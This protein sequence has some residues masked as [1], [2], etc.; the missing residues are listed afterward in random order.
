MSSA[1][2]DVVAPASRA[3][4]PAPRPVSLAAPLVWFFVSGACALV[5]QVVW[6]RRMVLLTGT[7]TAAVSTVLGVFMAGLGLGAWIFGVQADRSSR[8]LK[9][10]AYLEAGIALY[11]LA[12]PWLLGLCTPLYVEA[13]RELAGRPAPLLLL[14]VTLG[15][16]LLIVPTALM[17]GTFPALVRHVASDP[18]RFGT[19]LGVL[20]STNLAGGVAGSLAAGFVL[21]RALGVD[22]ATMAAVLANLA[23]AASALLW[24]ERRASPPAAARAVKPPAIGRTFPPAARPLVWATVAFSGVLTMAYEVLWTRILVFPFQ[25]T[26]YAFTLI[27][28][29]FLTGL[30]LGSRLYVAAERRADPLRVLALAQALAGLSALVF[31]PLSLY[32]VDVMRLALLWI[33]PGAGVFL[34]VTA[35]CAALV[36]LVPATFMGVVLPLGM[37]LLVDD[38]ARSGRQVG[39]AYL[40]NTGGSVAGALLA[41]FALIPLLGLKHA[42][43]LLAAAQVGLGGAFLGHLA[44]PP[45]RRRQVRAASAA[46][47]AVAAGGAAWLLSGPSPFDLQN[48]R[49]SSRPVIHA[50]RDAVGS[51]VSVVSAHAGEKMLRIDGVNAALEGAR[52]GY[53]PMMAHIPMLL[54]PDP[55][56]LLVICFGTG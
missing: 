14:R 22:G 35:L 36:M 11:A 29:T 45:P 27:L 47:L 7:T 8:P 30:A 31:T 42:L 18:A 25:S 2:A 12:L 33:H 17:G 39:L 19:H 50:H 15:F 24:R 26:V 10:Y 40:A 13:A 56:R 21:I 1:P 3:E 54:H 55:R 51:S 41:G 37:R 28:A 43:L 38:L 53:M 34:A 32:L 9:L 48:L 4:T 20:Y 46:L 5:Y 23:V 52:A 44:L 6:V 16:L 49:G